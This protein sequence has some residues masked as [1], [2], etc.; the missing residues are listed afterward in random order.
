MSAKIDFKGM[1]TAPGL[2]MRSPASCVS[3]VNFRIP[4]PG[5]M[6]KRTGFQRLSAGGSGGPLW[7][8]MSSRTLNNQVITH[9]GN[10]SAGSALRI[11]DGS[12]PLTLIT[13]TITR[14][15]NPRLKLTLAGP[16]HYLQGEEGPRRLE[17]N[18]SSLFYAGMPRAMAPDTYNMNA[19]AYTV[20]TPAAGSWLANG[21]NAAYRLTWHKK[22]ASGNYEL[23]GPPTGRV[24]IR[25]IAGS[26]GFTGGVAN[27]TLRIPLPVALGSSFASAGVSASYFWRLWRSRSAATGTADDEMYLVAEAFVTAGDIIAGYATVVDVTPDDILSRGPVLHTNAVNFPEAGITNGVVYADDSPPRCE[28]M[29]FFADCLFCG[30]ISGRASALLTLVTLPVAGDTITVNGVVLT[31]VAGAPGAA[32]FTAVAGLATL[33]LNLEATARNIV[34]AIRLI[35]PTAAVRAYHVSQGT[36]A[37]G[38]IFV[39]HYAFN[40]GFTMQ[41][42]VAVFRP[43][44]VTAQTFNPVTETNTIAFSKAGRPDA[45]PVVNRLTVGPSD[46]RILRMIPQRNQLIVFTDAGLFRVTGTT[47]FDF[48]VTAYDQTFRLWSHDLVAQVDDAVYAWGVEGIAK[49]TEAS[50][51]IISTPIEPTVLNLLQSQTNIDNIKLNGFAVGYRLNHKV[52]FWY[53]TSSSTPSCQDWLEYDT[54]TETWSLGDCRV[55]AVGAKSFG[56]ARFSDDR[57]ILVNW[58][59]TGIDAY[60]YAERFPWEATPYVDEASDGTTLTTQSSAQFQFQCPDVEA[61]P[62]WQQFLMQFE[63]GEASHYPH[64]TAVNVTWLVDATSEAYAATVS[65]PVLRLESPTSVRRDTRQQVTIAHTASEHCGI[66]LVDQTFTL[67]SRFPES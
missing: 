19:A 26:S 55:G 60:L 15:T 28:D 21:A 50:V 4:A 18:L 58:N 38:S 31:A 2:L 17:S 3:M 22:D 36:Q 43:N 20:I 1:V 47:A 24:V 53:N 35:G 59:G 10:A 30:N 32:Q 11:G 34:E 39:E 61:R 33:S 6:R 66:I 56:T 14:S 16:A 51:G 67:G 62:H 9:Q 40:T 41:S 44:I 57:L 13:G 46:S 48:A 42:S 64:P 52:Q 8:V 65:S 25:N 12:A 5:V 27:V 63:D 29:A 45:V 54:R 49:I 23:G 7:S 37:P